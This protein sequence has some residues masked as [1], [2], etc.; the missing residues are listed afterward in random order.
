MIV[1]WGGIGSRMSLWTSFYRRNTSHGFKVFSFTQVSTR[2]AHRSGDVNP[3]NMRFG[4][5][6]RAFTKGG[7][8]TTQQPAAAETSIPSIC[9]LVGCCV[10][11]LIVV[12][13]PSSPCMFLRGQGGAQSVPP[14]LLQNWQNRR[15][16]SVDIMGV[17]I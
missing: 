14:P 9:V 16:L 8:H 12:C 4:G 15:Q 13:F 2:T 6:G 10:D 5:A 3:V 17:L 1:I 11:R 7:V